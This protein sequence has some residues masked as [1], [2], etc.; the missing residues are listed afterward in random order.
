VRRDLVLLAA[1]EVG[2][3]RVAFGKYVDKVRKLED[4]GASENF[5]F[6]EL[7]E[8]AREFKAGNR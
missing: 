2:V 7:L 8:L 4:R 6:D 3:D 1:R 5:S